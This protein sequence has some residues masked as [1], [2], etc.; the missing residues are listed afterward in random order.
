[1][2]EIKALESNPYIAG[3]VSALR[4]ARGGAQAIGQKVLPEG[5][6]DVPADLLL[7]ESG[8]KEWE[9]IGYGNYPMH[10]PEMS[11]IPQFKSNRKAADVLDAVGMA[12]IGVATKAPAATA[13]AIFAPVAL[14]RMKT[15]DKATDLVKQI[16]LAEK[17]RAKGASKQDIWNAAKL[18]E[19]NYGVHSSRDPLEGK[20]GREADVTTA[21]TKFAPWF[22]AT[23]ND[24]TDLANR[25]GFIETPEY[26]QLHMPREDKLPLSMALDSKGVEDL[27]EQY[28]ELASINMQFQPGRNYFGQY[29]PS[30][31]TAQIGGKT[32]FDSRKDYQPLLV[33]L[34]ELQ[35]GVQH[36]TG[37]PSGGTP[38]PLSDRTRDL[39]PGVLN[40]L[41]Q[42]GED[43]NTR[44]ADRLDK[45]MTTSDHKRYEDL[46][47]EKQARAASD[48]AAASQSYRDITPPSMTQTGITE[49]GMH[50]YLWRLSEFGNNIS[51]TGPNA[52]Q[53][54][55]DF[56]LHTLRRTN[57]VK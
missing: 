17:L 41:R 8:I 13:K 32:M 51:F 46:I 50:P 3:L 5:W 16:E 18:E 7:P 15:A 29:N 20:W 40:Y 35:H 25:L 14:S 9:N 34:H 10:V 6:G 21:N 39:L 24:K 57:L 33:A 26:Q 54:Q 19:V 28:P 49:E 52:D 36:K 23:Q 44:L 27:A 38:G 53:D 31:F 12:P 2:D 37:M 45:G 43:W 11:N 22:E 55:L 4:K 30:D 42:S 47:G 56:L 48:R 1:M